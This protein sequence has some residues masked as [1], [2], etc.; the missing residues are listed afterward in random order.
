MTPETTK[1]SVER[2]LHTVDHELDDWSLGTP[3][4]GIPHA[5]ESHP[6]P[7]DGDPTMP[8]SSNYPRAAAEGADRRSDPRGGVHLGS[9]AEV[10]E[11]VCYPVSSRRGDM[12]T[13]NVRLHS[14]FGWI[15]SW[16]PG[17]PGSLL[18]HRISN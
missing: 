3:I 5:S 18:S 8:N 14:G 7:H 11:N 2:F 6:G 17:Y 10:V 13:G 15:V 12:R 4:R 1:R 9:G 16:R